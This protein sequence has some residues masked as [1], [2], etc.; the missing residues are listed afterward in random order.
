MEKNKK[1]FAENDLVKKDI[2][3]PTLEQTERFIQTLIRQ[4]S[5]HKHVDWL[6]PQQFLFYLD[7][8][9]AYWNYRGPYPSTVKE[10]NFNIAMEAYPSDS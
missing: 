10:T 3:K 5:W 8:N 7:P 4:H 9:T 6:N 2:P 1:D